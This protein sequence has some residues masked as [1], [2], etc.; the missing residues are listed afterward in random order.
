[1]SKKQ[2]SWDSDD[3][4]QLREV[5]FRKVS[6]YFLFFPMP[7]NLYKTTPPR[8]KKGFEYRNEKNLEI[9]LIERFGLGHFVINQMLH[10]KFV[11]LRFW[12]QNFGFWLTNSYFLAVLGF[13]YLI[14]MFYF[15]FVKDL[16]MFGFRILRK[17]M[18]NPYWF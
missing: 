13:G 4:V 9:N 11:K 7:K 5:F 17:E 6:I 3:A 12:F 15:E 16:L 14:L 1:V 8:T 18:C 2:I 10:F